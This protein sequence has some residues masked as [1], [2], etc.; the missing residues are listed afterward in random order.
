[1]AISPSLPGRMRYPPSLCCLTH[2]SSP[3]L[4]SPHFGRSRTAQYQAV[5]G[6]SWKQA[7]GFLLRIKPLPQG[8][9]HGRRHRDSLALS[10]H[11]KLGQ[12]VRGDL[13]WPQASRQTEVMPGL[14]LRLCHGNGLYRFPP[15]NPPKT[16]P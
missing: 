9:P 7:L 8:L 5:T 13:D 12:H 6:Q 11:P 1:L 3:K 14:P 16:Q 2:S 10:L 4:E 15:R